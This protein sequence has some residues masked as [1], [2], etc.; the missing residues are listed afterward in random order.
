M[1]YRGERELELEEAERSAKSARPAETRGRVRPVPGIQTA[2][3]NSQIAVV[4]EPPGLSAAAELTLVRE[5]RDKTESSHLLLTPQPH[6]Q[7]LTDRTI[8]DATH[9]KLSPR[10]AAYSVPDVEQVGVLPRL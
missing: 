10:K 8:S 5:C 6:R 4:G 9:R 2:K 1:R 3:M 7:G